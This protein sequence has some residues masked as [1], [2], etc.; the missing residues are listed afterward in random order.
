MDDKINDDNY[1]KSTDNVE[2]NN[3]N[4]MNCEVMTGL[5]DSDIL[6]L[7]NQIKKDS[8]LDLNNIEKKSCDI[9]NLKVLLA[10]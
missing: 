7:N 9:I 2:K 4:K 1:V 3:I 10:S 5:T 6:K 8:Q